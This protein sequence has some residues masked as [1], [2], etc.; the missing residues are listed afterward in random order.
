MRNRQQARIQ[1]FSMSHPERKHNSGP[2]V[3]RGLLFM[4]HNITAAAQPLERKC[5]LL[6][7]GA[8]QWQAPGDSLGT[9]GGFVKSYS[10]P[11]HYPA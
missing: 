8:P 4:G 2:R 6:F 11:A 3:F 10:D 1:L 9:G 7:I 5:G